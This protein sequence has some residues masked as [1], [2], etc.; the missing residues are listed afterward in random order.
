MYAAEKKLIFRKISVSDFLL[1]NH[2]SFN[3]LNKVSLLETQDIQ[4]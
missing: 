1:G 4:Y 3:F 2:S